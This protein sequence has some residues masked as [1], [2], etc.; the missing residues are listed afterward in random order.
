M[1]L[2]IQAELAR[3]LIIPTI[4]LISTFSPSISSDSIIENSDPTFQA[5]QR[6]TNQSL[7]WGTYRPNLYFGLRP[8]QPHS[9]MT[10]MLWFGTQDFQSFAREYRNFGYH[11]IKC[12]IETNQK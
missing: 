10:G 6:A 4:L 7:L 5:L 12:Q 9:L 2:T 8:R 11:L 3:L 1:L